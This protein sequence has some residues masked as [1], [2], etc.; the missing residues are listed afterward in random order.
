[1]KNPPLIL[2]SPSVADRGTEFGDRS[3]SLSECYSAAIIAAGGL[4]LVLPCL[5]DPALVAAAVARCDGVLLTGGEDLPP[6][7][8]DPHLPD[9]IRRTVTIDAPER[10]ALE[11]ELVNQVFRQQKPLLAICRGHQVLNVALG[12][13]LITDIPLQLP[14][15]LHHKRSDAKNNPVHEITVKSGSILAQYADNLTMS[16][17]SSHHQ[18]LGRVAEPLLVTAASPDGVIEAVELRPG[19]NRTL[20]YLLSVQFHPERLFDRYPRFKEMFRGFVQACEKG[21]IPPNECK[22]TGS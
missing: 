17:N 3:L 20:P 6:E 14:G 5:T 1:M 12:G 13:T 19:S 21:W 10:D 4:P 22:N 7:L 8:Y 2:V 15:A 18:A 9:E 16:V 11:F